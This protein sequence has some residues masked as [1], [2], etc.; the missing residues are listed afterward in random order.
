MRQAKSVLVPSAEFYAINWRQPIFAPTQ[1]WSGAGW[2]HCVRDGSVSVVT[3][4]VTSI[5]L[6][7]WT[8]YMCGY[9]PYSNPPF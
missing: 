8:P 9:Q 3:A 6:R 7:T 4:M 1:E 5:E 2:G